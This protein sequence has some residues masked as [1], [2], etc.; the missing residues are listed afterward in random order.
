[1]PRALGVWHPLAMKSSRRMI[2]AG[3]L[4]RFMSQQIFM[5][6]LVSPSD[7]EFETE[8]EGLELSVFIH[9]LP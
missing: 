4:M 7:L 8:I 9:D 2:H 5:L 3:I 1:M 6:Q